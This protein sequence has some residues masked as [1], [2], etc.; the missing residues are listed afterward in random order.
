MFRAVDFQSNRCCFVG[1][2]LIPGSCPFE[3]ENAKIWRDLA[4]SGRVC[5]FE[6]S[7]PDDPRFLSSILARERTLI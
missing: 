4:D 2:S 5:I 7:E 6:K 3:Y 1:A